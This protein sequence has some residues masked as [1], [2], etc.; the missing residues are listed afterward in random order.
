VVIDGFKRVRVLRKL[1]RDR[2]RASVW[3]VDEAEALLLERLLRGASED[4]LEQ[5]WVLS[6]LC[7]RFGLSRDELAKRMDKSKSWVSRRLALVKEL[8]EALQEHVRGG[9]IA[10]HAAMKYLVPL[11]RANTDAAT[12]L[13]AV[14]APLKPTTR[15]VGELYA[16]WQSGT[17]KTRELILSS[18][19][20]YLRAQ[21]EQRR[22]RGAEKSFSQQL[23]DDLGVLSGVAHRARRRLD[24]GVVQRL[25]ACEL[26]EVVQRLKQ[27]RADTLGLFTRFDREVNH[28]G[29]IHAGGDPQAA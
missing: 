20:L 24:Q 6:E 12:R 26:E 9:E 10:A 4:A 25:L 15:Q 18:P 17:S 5:G 16:G 11:A 13:A 23:L 29:P 14:I 28:A 27:A 2:V 8:P 21:E 1:S 19:Q 3:E 7:E 22:V